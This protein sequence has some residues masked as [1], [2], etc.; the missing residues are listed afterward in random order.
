M[1][2]LAAVLAGLAC[3]IAAPVHAVASEPARS[4]DAAVPDPVQ[5][6]GIIRRA[7]GMQTL[8]APE[9]K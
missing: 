9:V 2:R 4:D 6:H 5:M 7:A 3:A 8:G 1:F